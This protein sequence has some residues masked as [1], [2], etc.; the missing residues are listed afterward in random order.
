MICATVLIYCPYKQNKRSNMSDTS[1]EYAPDAIKLAI[2]LI[3]FLE[4]NTVV[5]EVVLKVLAI[6]QRDFERKFVVTILKVIEILT[7]I[8][9]PF[10]FVYEL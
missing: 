7:F 6:V 4:K 2:S 3:C 5:P 10:I 9:L 8:Y 1:L